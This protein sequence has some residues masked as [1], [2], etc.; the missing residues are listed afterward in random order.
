MKAF[1]G[2]A[3]FL[4]FLAAF[5]LAL[6]MARQ[7]SRGDGADEPVPFTDIR[8]RPVAVGDGRFPDDTPA[9][10]TIAADGTINGH[11]G[12]NRFSGVLLRTENGVEIGPL[13]TTRR[14]C[15]DSQMRL[16]AALLIALERARK[17]RA[18]GDVLRLLGPDDEDM[19]RFIAT[20]RGLQPDP[21][22]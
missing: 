16:E 20:D 14:A 3:F 12:C 15:P 18:D 19:A 21:P 22:R 10:M 8:W 17:L 4:L 9:F 11:A 2:F 1:V 5:A 7:S 6:L 13:A